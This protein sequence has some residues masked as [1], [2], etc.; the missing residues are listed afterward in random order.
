MIS[1][2]DGRV[3]IVGGS[4]PYGDNTDQGNGLTNA[5][6]TPTIWNPSDNSLEQAE[7]QELARLYHSSGLLLPDGS[8]WSGGGGA[9]GPL[10]NTNVGNFSSL[11]ISYDA[12]G[13]LAERPEITAA[14]NE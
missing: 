14:P 5:V 12:N 4:T 2:P 11:T 6:Y 7:A 1:L 8:V 10:I 13:N 9:P 3:L